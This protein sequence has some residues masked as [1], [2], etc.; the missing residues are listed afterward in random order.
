MLFASNSEPSFVLRG[1]S[2]PVNSIDSFGS[3]LLVSGDQNG[4]IVAWNLVLKKKILK[5]EKAHSSSILS[6]NIFYQSQYSRF[7]IISATIE[8]LAS[9]NIDS[10]SFTRFTFLSTENDD[11]LVYLDDSETNKIGRLNLNSESISELKPVFFNLAMLMALK[12][13]Q[14]PEKLILV[15]GYEDGSLATYSL[16]PGLE[17]F[18]LIDSVLLDQASPLDLDCIVIPPNFIRL[19]KDSKLD[20]NQRSSSLEG[21]NPTENSKNSDA[22]IAQQENLLASINSDNSVLLAIGGSSKIVFIK[23]LS[24]DGLFKT[25]FQKF[26]LKNYGINSL[27]FFTS[28]SSALKQGHTQSNLCKY[29][30]LVA[31]ACWDHRVRVLNVSDGSVET[32]INFHSGPSTCISFAS[33]F[34]SFISSSHQANLHGD[35]ISPRLFPDCKYS[36]IKTRNFVKSST[37]NSDKEVQLSDLDSSKCLYYLNSDSSN[38]QTNA[39]RILQNI[40]TTWLIASS[41]DHRISLWKLS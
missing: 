2:S 29:Q 28:S 32:N 16:H 37:E 36:S 25:P 5:L 4:T 8:L 21:G 9:F 22:S 14:S 1:H 18:S 12:L 38:I 3:T 7:L 34:S 20:S 10:I 31:L 40:N 33:P 24:N 19:M 35:Q 17:S 39:S 11:W 30:I 26:S 13:L 6:L 23:L 27:R 41:Q 15:C